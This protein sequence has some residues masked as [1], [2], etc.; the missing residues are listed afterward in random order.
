[1]KQPRLT[2]FG[3]VSNDGHLILPKA[4]RSEVVRWFLGKEIEV[5]FSQKKK[6]RS[7][8]QNAYYWGVVIDLICQAMNEAGDLVKPQEV[9]EFLKHRFLKI[10][11][12]DIETG[13]LLYEYSRSTTDLSTFEFSEYV[14]R[15]VQFAAEF[16]N[17]EIAMPG[18]QI[19]I[20]L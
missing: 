3:S 20:E 4:I 14:E 5:S 15:C 16:L 10:Q 6:P 1:M 19:K 12:I 7:N 13:E 2:Y 18:E 9:H 8:P 11:K 17:I